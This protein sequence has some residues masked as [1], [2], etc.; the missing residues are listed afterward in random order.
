MPK[1][2]VRWADLKDT[3]WKNGGGTTRVLA[4]GPTEAGSTG[5][6]GSAW[7]VSVAEITA[8]GPFSDFPGVDRVLT[9]V[10]GE[11]LVLNVGDS[12]HH[13]RRFDTLAFAGDATTACRLPV[14]PAR[15]L[16]LMTRRGRAVGTSHVIEVTADHEA[17]V[18]DDQTVILVSLTVGLELAGGQA[19]RLWDSVV[20]DTPGTVRVAGRGTLAEVRVTGRASGPS[21]MPHPE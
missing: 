12:E 19:L 3:P 9:L 18:H 13:L 11:G 7:T 8:D 16:N 10:D 21:D 1:D 17:E 5:S 14:G 4:S 2:L 6:T 20:H 15:A